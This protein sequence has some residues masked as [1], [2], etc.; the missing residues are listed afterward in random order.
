M[1]KWLNVC[2]EKKAPLAMFFYQVMCFIRN[3]AVRKKKSENV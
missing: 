2:I 3:F 1:D